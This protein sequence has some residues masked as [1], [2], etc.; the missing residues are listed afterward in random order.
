MQKMENTRGDAKLIFLH[1][2]SV[3][4][5]AGSKLMV[6]DSLG[7]NLEIGYSKGFGVFG[8]SSNTYTMYN[9]DQETLSIL[10]NEI[11]ESNNF[12]I[13]AGLVLSF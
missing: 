11:S 2:I 7:F 1:I 8:G 9:P 5:S 10:A 13:Q 4:V 3:G 12:G 6:S